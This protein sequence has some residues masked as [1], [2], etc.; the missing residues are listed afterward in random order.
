MAWHG[1][2]KP[3]REH[4]HPASLPGGTFDVVRRAR[5]ANHL[6][7]TEP[8]DDIDRSRGLEATERKA[9]PLRHLVGEQSADQVCADWELIGV[10]IHPTTVPLGQ[11]DRRTV[12]TRDPGL[13][14]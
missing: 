9:G 10:E 4:G 7:I 5:K 2:G 8:E 3:R 12:G 1:E 6:V 14:E 13:P 11:Q